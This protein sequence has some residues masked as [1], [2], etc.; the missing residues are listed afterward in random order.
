[1]VA[2]RTPG[3]YLTCYEPAGARLWLANCRPSPTR[4]AQ[5][6]LSGVGRMLGKRPLSGIGTIPM[7]SQFGDVS[8]YELPVGQSFSMTSRR[9]K[10]RPHAPVRLIVLIVG[11]LL[12]GSGCAI[13]DTVADCGARLRFEG[14]TYHGTGVVRTPRADGVLGTGTVPTC[15][16]KAVAERMRVSRIKDVAP[17]DA[18]IADGQVWVSGKR[19]SRPAA[20]REA[21]ETV[22]CTDPTRFTG[23][24]IGVE[25]ETRRDHELSPPYDAT[26]AVGDGTNLP[27]DRWAEVEIEA[28]ITGETSPVPSRDFV[29]RALGGA[30]LVTVTAHCEGK[31]FEVDEVAFAR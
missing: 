18:L 2:G 4:S 9:G 30:R 28:R 14:R 25:A 24:W 8:L 15:D 10:S 26:F 27:L 5:R 7:R 21:N 23:V 20:L 3:K 1:M 19:G 13:T 6:C 12:L 17:A 11:A 29:R 22:P 16:G 31:R